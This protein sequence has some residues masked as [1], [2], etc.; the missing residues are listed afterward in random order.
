MV[1]EGGNP[2]RAAAAGPLNLRLMA[3]AHHQHMADLALLQVLAGVLW[4]LL[5]ED[6]NEP[7][8]QAE[9]SLLHREANGRGG[10]A[11]A[12]GEHNVGGLRVVRSPVPLGADLAV[13]QQHKGVHLNAAAVELVQHV[14]N[15]PGRDAQA[16][17]RTVL[18]IHNNYLAFL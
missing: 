4:G 1:Q 17:W 13:A 8:I 2:V 7:V 3:A 5:G 18:Q 15:G 16:F 12:K 6:I 11:F 9:N 14:H 10:Q